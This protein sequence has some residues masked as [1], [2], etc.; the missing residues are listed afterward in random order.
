MSRCPVHLTG[1]VESQSPDGY[2]RASFDVSSGPP[3]SAGEA[4]AQSDAV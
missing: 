1:S 2:S 4:A 3:D